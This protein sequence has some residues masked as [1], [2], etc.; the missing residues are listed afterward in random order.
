M[1][2]IGKIVQIGIIDSATYCMAFEPLC[3]LPSV[4]TMAVP[5]KPL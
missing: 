1:K 3:L 5:L 2:G 4:V